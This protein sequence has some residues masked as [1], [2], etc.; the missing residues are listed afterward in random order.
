MNNWEYAAL[1][2]TSPW[3]GAMSI[4][5]ELSL[6]RTSHGID[7]VQQPIPELE[8]LRG[9]HFQAQNFQLENET[10]ALPIGG[11]C[12][13]IQAEFSLKTAEEFGFW[14]GQDIKIAY[15]STSQELF[16]LRSQSEQTDFHANFSGRHHATLIE[17]GTLKLHIFIDT[18]S[19]EVFVQDGEIVLTDLVFFSPDTALELYAENGTVLVNNLNVWELE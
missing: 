8:Q 4:P 16:I 19:L 2:P 18:C 15:S 14:L 5:R 10:R 12:L 13:E 3:R 11:T 7:L 1:T 6:R 17:Q 9:N